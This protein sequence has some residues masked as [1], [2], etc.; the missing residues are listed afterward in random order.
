MKTEDRKII[1]MDEFDL[2]SYNY[3]ISEGN[4]KTYATIN[5][6]DIGLIDFE[7]IEETSASTV[8][9]SVGETLFVIKW[10]EGYTPTFI[11]DGSVISVGTYS[12]QEILA[13]LQTP[14]WIEPIEEKEE[15]EIKK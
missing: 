5:L 10:K 15:E 3:S 1:K 2:E 9:K 13:L 12:H 8:R 14:E 4:N 6:S 11:K 7:Q